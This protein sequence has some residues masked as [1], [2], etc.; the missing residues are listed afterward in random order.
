MQNL[1][2]TENIEKLGRWNEKNKNTLLTH[3]L[4]RDWN[5]FMQL[6]IHRL[7]L[8][9]KHWE[10]VLPPCYFLWIGPALQG[11]GKRREYNP[12]SRLI[13]LP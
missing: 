10:T 6:L 1:D 2:I 5:V 11:G 12:R 3:F 7:D 8:D 9:S 13:R 4:L